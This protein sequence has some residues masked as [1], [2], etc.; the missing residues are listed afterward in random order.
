[1]KIDLH[2]HTRRYSGCSSIE[3]EEVLEAAKQAG[4]DGLALTEHGILWPQDRLEA[5]KYQAEELG[6]VL[7]AGQEI[8]CLDRGRRM[9]F[10]VFGLSES[11]GT[12]ANPR[13]L[14]EYVHERNGVVV[15]AHPF[16]HSRLGVGYHGVGE[17]VY[18]LDLDA[19]ELFHPDHDQDAKEKVR[20][21]AEILDLPLTG[22]SDAHES[23]QIGVYAT[24]FER[25]ISS[26]PDLDREI[27][28]G[29]MKPLDKSLLEGKK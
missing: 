26:I 5:L 24:M 16:K 20:A 29:R 13:E 9:D 10:L 3:P 7:L 28:A 18:N 15:A 2:V 6:L 19:I 8:T 21:A 27:K 23:W 12:R 22:G 14:I 4:V 25:P 1:V 11:M 17:N